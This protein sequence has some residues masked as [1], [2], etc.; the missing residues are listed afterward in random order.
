[1]VPC[2][3]CGGNLALPTLCTTSSDDDCDYTTA[4][5]GCTPPAPPSSRAAAPTTTTCVCGTCGAV[6]AV[7]DATRA[8]FE[9]SPTS[10]MS[11]TRAAEVQAALCG[12]TAYLNAKRDELET[13]RHRP[14]GAAPAAAAVFG[15]ANGGRDPRG[16]VVRKRVDDEETT[17]DDDEDDEDEEHE[18]RDHRTRAHVR[19]AAETAWGM[20]ARQKRGMTQRDAGAAAR[21]A[22]AGANDVP[23]GEQTPPPGQMMIDSGPP[24]LGSVQCAQKPPV[25]TSLTAG[26]IRSRSLFV[27]SR[28]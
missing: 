10:A 14:G 9:L 12:R 8:R 1:M 23:L 24:T 2:D 19:A 11:A 25:E 21:A 3:A 22:A 20:V 18:P 5:P 28:E 15:G 13:L 26:F 4:N 27:S 17:R 16:G 7:G 6:N